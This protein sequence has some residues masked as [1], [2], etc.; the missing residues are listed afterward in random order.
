MARA[1]YT[2]EVLARARARQRDY[3]PL[4][5][6]SLFPHPGHVRNLL[7]RARALSASRSCLD[8]TRSILYAIVTLLRN[9]RV[10]RAR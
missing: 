5:R 10:G 9:A 1:I 3:S 6:A 7:C 8:G 2:A 4:A